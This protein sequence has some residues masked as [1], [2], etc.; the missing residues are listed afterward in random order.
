MPRQLKQYIYIR[1]PTLNPYIFFI[2]NDYDNTTYIKYYG[3]LKK[4]GILYIIL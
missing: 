4:P 2:A 3:K 1:V